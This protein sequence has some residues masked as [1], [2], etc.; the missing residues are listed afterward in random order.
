MPLQKMDEI[1]ARLEDYLDEAN[2]NEA[3]LRTRQRIVRVAS[4]LFVHHGYRKT[5][6]S[7]IAKGAG[8][9]KGTLYLHF[10][11]KH[12]LV[13][14]AIVYE[15]RVIVERVRIALELPEEQRLRAYLRVVLK[16]AGEMPLVGRLAR[17]DHEMITVLSE[18]PPEERARWMHDG[19]DFFGGLLDAAAGHHRW[20]PSE[21]ADRALVMRALVYGAATMTEPS[22]LGDLSAERFADILADLLLDGIRP[23]PSENPT[24]AGGSS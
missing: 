18:A 21:L 13:V 24:S 20:T 19:E 8:V 16:L 4:E 22:I 12:D 15:K 14:T 3:K 9:A 1:R 6:M 23:R 10:A 11:N 2:L 5:S 17:G 7:D